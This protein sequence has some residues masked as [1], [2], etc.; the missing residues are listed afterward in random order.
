ML[1]GATVVLTLLAPVLVGLYS[2]FGNPTQNALATTFAYW[3]IPQLFF[4][5][6]YGLLGRCSTRAARSVRTCGR[7]P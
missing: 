2:N 4:Y 6:V 3:C 7:P 1:A 5:G